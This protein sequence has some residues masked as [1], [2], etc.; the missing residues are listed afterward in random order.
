MI[1]SKI[2]V[3]MAL[4]SLTVHATTTQENKSIADALAESNFVEVN[5]GDVLFEGV[6]FLVA[7]GWQSYSK[8]LG[9]LQL[10][11][12]REICEFLGYSGPI[13]ST[14]SNI[15]GLFVDVLVV[16]NGGIVQTTASY[17][18]N[19]DVAVFDSLWCKKEI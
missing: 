16:T 9:T 14:V 6:P 17:W 11:R 8:G 19:F 15:R 13:V 4:A 2:F 18:K 1:F 7:D 3:A 12:G 5:L 10:Q